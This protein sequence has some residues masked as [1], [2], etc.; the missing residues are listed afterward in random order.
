MAT[1]VSGWWAACIAVGSGCVSLIKLAR[2]QPHPAVQVRPVVLRPQ[3]TPTPLLFQALLFPSS[4]QRPHR[5]SLL[6]PGQA[7][8]TPDPP[9][10]PPTW[11]PLSV[12]S[13]PS[14]LMNLGQSLRA[15]GSTLFWDRLKEPA[16][17]LQLVQKLWLLGLD[18]VVA[19]GAQEA[20]GE[21]H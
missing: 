18:H 6:L 1:S 20:Q 9:S 16:V 14:V 4:L 2:P 5:Q 13:P 11:D 7:P 21:A 19:L 8:P 15:Q 17:L 10:H 12:P 3:F